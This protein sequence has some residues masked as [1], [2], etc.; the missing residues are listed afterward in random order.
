MLN[1]LLLYTILVTEKIYVKFEQNNT[2]LVNCG[3]THQVVKFKCKNSQNKTIYLT[4]NCPKSIFPKGINFD[5]TYFLNCKFIKT[6]KDSNKV[7]SLA[8]KE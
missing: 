5:S 3:I 7:Y 4:I 2:W 6:D 8:E 1:I